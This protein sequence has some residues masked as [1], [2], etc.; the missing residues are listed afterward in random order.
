[1]RFQVVRAL[2]RIPSEASF[3]ALMKLYGRGYETP[4]NQA[5]IVRAL[6]AMSS[7]RA[8]RALR[9]QL[10]SADK[11]QLG[12]N[13]FAA[14]WMSRHLMDRRT[15]AGDVAFAL[16]SNN[17]PLVVAATEASA[18]LRQASLVAPLTRLVENQDAEIR[19]KAVYAL[20]RIGDRRAAQVLLAQ[21]PKVRDARMLNN[22][23]FA[24]V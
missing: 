13:V 21:L 7:Q 6:G 16:E 1:V 24:Q 15:L 22:I 4:E 23:A 3:D 14:L 20:G 11:A 8:V 10:R 19:N 18:E 12:L 17:P 2:E 9:A 5:A